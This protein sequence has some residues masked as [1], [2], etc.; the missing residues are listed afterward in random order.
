MKKII[1]FFKSDN[2]IEP[3]IKYKGIAKYAPLII[4]GGFYL[5][6]ILLFIF[7]PFEWNIT[8]G[9]QLYM[10]LF[11]ALIALIAGYILGVKIRRK[12][13]K[14][15]F[16]I[17]R[18][19]YFSFIVFL[20]MYFFNNYATTG[21]IFPDVVNGL[22]NSGE[23]YSNSHNLSSFSIFIIYIGILISPLTAF[24]TP[25]FF[26]YYKN[27]SKKAK[28]LGIVVLILNLCTGI[29]QG[30]I[31]AYAVL[32]F[33]IIM[34]LLIYLFSN[35]KSKS[36][37]EITKIIILILCIGFSFI[38][39]Y[40]IVM[41]NRLIKDATPI[42]SNSEINKENNNQLVS[43]DQTENKQEENK[44][45]EN[46]Q[47]EN[48]KPNV[49]KEDKISNSEMNDMFD[50]S[51]EYIAQSTIKEKHIFTFLP[52]SIEGSLNHITSYITHGYKGLSFAMTKKFTSSY[53]L[54]FSDFFRHNLLKIVGKTE[55]E[56]E[57]Y[58]RTYM[59]KIEVNGWS[60]GNVWSTFFVYPASDIGFPMTIILVY[61][62][63][64]VFS[65]S[66]RDAIE[67][68]NIF[69]GVIFINLCM[70]ICFF[71]AN[72]VYFQNGGTFI[73]FVII[74]ILWILSRIFGKK[75]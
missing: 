46:K 26:I 71:C 1:N 39:Y 6:T 2:Q 21:K 51:A 38:F 54:G 68:K 44:Q 28:I 18:I 16:N 48:N 3:L 19:I 64:L 60:T 7:G 41:G 59:K 47:E 11:L 35:L 66:W 72:N 75:V 61:F 31:N 22:F 52:D 4:C 25:L 37:K 49:S 62:I 27:L 17:N 15:N 42:E 53:G 50:G 40:K 32:A 12:E 67:S 55:I 30:V 33:Q 9:N 5:I 13:T 8:N 63:G 73:S 36:W 69:A 65:L 24:L 70:I 56:D 10:F 29:A 45:E 20:I 14:S 58:A 34:F 23:A 74:S 57:I 43:E